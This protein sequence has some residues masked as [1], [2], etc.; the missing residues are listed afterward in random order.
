[1]LI[2]MGPI[3]GSLW[4]S[5]VRTECSAFLKRDVGISALAL[6]WLSL[7]TFGLVGIF[8]RPL[9][10]APLV[11]EVQSRAGVLRPSVRRECYALPFFH[12]LFVQEDLIAAWMA[13]DLRRR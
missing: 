8:W 10:L 1:M 12:A 5:R 11:E 3:G 6:P 7:F 4:L 13:D 2:F 9:V